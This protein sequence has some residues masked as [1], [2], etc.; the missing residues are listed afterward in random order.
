[1]KDSELEVDIRSIQSQGFV[2]P[3][4]GRHQ[5]AEK[6]RIGVGAKAFGRGKLLGSAKKLL[7]LFIAGDVRGLS[8]VTMREES[9]GRNLG[10][11][12]NNAIPD[13]EASDD[14]ETL[15][16]GKRL[17]FRGPRGPAKHQLAG[18]ARGSLGLDKGHEI[19]QPT[20]L[21]LELKPKAATDA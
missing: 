14:A 1:V 13:S 2:H 11:W 21:F 20:L 6:G 16:P 9:C 18:D 8:P 19:P 10:A 12:F 17:R 5:Q 3:H 4:S 7:N 15:S